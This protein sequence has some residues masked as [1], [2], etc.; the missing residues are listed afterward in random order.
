MSRHKTIPKEIREQLYEKYNRR[1]A[2][3]GCE[4]KSKDM[5]IDHVESIYLHG[6][7]KQDMTEAEL[8]DTGNLLPA[9]RHCNLY[10]FAAG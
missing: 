8:Y 9:C 1:C 4:L 2:Y 5:Q 10:A 7:Y 6:D 3:C